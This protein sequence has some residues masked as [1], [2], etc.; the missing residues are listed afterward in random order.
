MLTVLYKSRQYMQARN[1][2]G[3]LGGAKSFLRGAQI[4]ETMS[5]SFK[6]CPT[7]F[8]RKGKNFSRGA[9]PPCA[10]SGYGPEYMYNFAS[11]LI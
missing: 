5:T 4:F 8:S 2:L 11:C 6:I 9:K 10:T 7:H 1:Q 3:T